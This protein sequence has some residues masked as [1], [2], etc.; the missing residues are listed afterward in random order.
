[1]IEHGF[2]TKLIRMVRATLDGLQSSVR[3]LDM[4]RTSFVTLYGLKESGFE[5]VCMYVLL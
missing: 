3:Y 2:P 4:I 1:M 5:F